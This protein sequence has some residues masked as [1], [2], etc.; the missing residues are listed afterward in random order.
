MK[1]VVV[2]YYESP[3]IVGYAD[4]I[5][6]AKQIEQQH[7]EDTDGECRTEIIS[8]GSISARVKV[9]DTYGQEFNGRTTQAEK[10]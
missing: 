4:N 10:R 2:D 7:N 5:K 9:G 1:Y 3:Y 6:E 8:L